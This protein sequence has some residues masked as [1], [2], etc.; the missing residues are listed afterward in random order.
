MSAGS[1][2]EATALGKANWGALP[3]TIPTLSLVC[4]YQN[5][6]PVIA[7]NLEVRSGARHPSNNNHQS[8]LEASYPSSGSP[9]KCVEGTEYLGRN[10]GVEQLLHAPAA[11]Q[12]KMGPDRSWLLHA[13][14]PVDA[15]RELLRQWRDGSA[16]CMVSAPEIEQT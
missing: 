2:I 15:S 8:I 11:R 1:N 7:S 5:V 6:V 14:S 12:S 3:D 9:K 13:C 10:L 16:G 4:V